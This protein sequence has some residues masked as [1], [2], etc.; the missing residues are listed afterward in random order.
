[1][2]SLKIDYETPHELME[3][4]RQHP[5]EVAEID[6]QCAE[7]NKKVDDLNMKLEIITA[8][9]IDEIVKRD[10]I[11]PSARQEVRRGMVQLDIRW[12]KIR[13]KLNEA[14]EQA[15]ILNGRSKGMFMRGR[16][17]EMLGKVELRSF[18]GEPT[19]YR[20][21]RNP[22]TKSKEMSDNL[23]MPDED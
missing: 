4:F 21:N 16:L 7:A 22:D 2:K 14:I 6:R 19:V 8:E 12:Q 18:F 17:L 3:I 20:D 1:M 15:T 13:R 23:E 9:I 5:R 11:P 10:K